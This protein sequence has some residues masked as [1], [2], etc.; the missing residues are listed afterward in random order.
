MH[1]TQYMEGSSE[2]LRT[3][4]AAVVVFQLCHQMATFL[5]FSFSKLTD[6][7][8]IQPFFSKRRNNL[9]GKLFVETTWSTKTFT[10]FTVFSCWIGHWTSCLDGN[11][12]RNEPPMN[13]AVSCPGGDVARMGVTVWTFGGATCRICVDIVYNIYIYI[14]ICTMDLYVLFVRCC[15]EKPRIYFLNWHN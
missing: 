12:T 4:A 11:E 14:Y 7:T 15:H 2:T 10:F 1:I 3:E 5:A 6:P 13:G 8:A 9:F